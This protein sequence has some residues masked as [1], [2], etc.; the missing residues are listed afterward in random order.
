MLPFIQRLSQL[1]G[2]SRGRKRA[3]QRRRERTP[4]LAVRQLEERRV[5]HAAAI[6]APVAGQT[7]PVPSPPPATVVTLDASHNLLVT[8]GS[9]A[10]QGA[11][12]RIRFDAA[13]S[14]FEITDA[15]N[16]LQSPIVGAT[17]NDSHSLFIP[18]HLVEGN[19]LIVVGGEGDDALAIDLSAG[20]G[21]KSLRF[22][23]GGGKTL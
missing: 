12:L 15:A 22:D 7:T 11:C 3:E 6:A 8:Q 1:F 4:Q 10:G 2:A 23:G 16:V 19:K 13:H 9:S 14:G 5:F 17:G 20:L 18:V 21:G